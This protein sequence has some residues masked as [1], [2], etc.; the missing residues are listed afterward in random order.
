MEEEDEVKKGGG[1]VIICV[2]KL[3]AEFT[4]KIFIQQK[5]FTR[6]CTLQIY[7]FK[8]VF[9]NIKSIT[10]SQGFQEHLLSCH[11]QFQI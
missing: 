4:K 2:T 3:N 6:G 10:E 5:I 11:M 1:G 8:I 7:L 9:E